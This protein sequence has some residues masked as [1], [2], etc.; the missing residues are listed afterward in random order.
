M[1]GALR[2]IGEDYH[3]MGY[4]D[5][6]QQAFDEALVLWRRIKSKAQSA[7]L[8]GHMEARNYIVKPEL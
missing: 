3:E 2:S 8:I 7:D 6:A 1:A 4:R 5:E